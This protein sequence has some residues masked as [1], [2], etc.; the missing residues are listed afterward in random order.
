[1]ILPFLA[2]ATTPPQQNASPAFTSFGAGA[3]KCFSSSL[4]SKVWSSPTLA[5]YWSRTRGRSFFASATSHWRTLSWT[6]RSESLSN[7]SSIRFVSRVSY[8][9]PEP[10]AFS[11]SRARSKIF[12]TSLLRRWSRARRD[13]LITF[14]RRILRLT[15]LCFL[16]RSNSCSSAAF[17]VSKIEV[18]SMRYCS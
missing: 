7:A 16:L 1:M 4:M 5:R 11:P 10:N 17:S 14:D 18:R 3:R 13:A 9:G 6:V 15:S 2:D 8:C 12:S